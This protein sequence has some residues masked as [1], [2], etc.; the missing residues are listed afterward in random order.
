MTH[1]LK[2]MTTA[3]AA[4]A[5]FAIASSGPS[6]ALTAQECSAKYATAKTAGTLKGMKWNEFRKAECADA[7][8][9]APAAAADAK[10]AAKPATVAGAGVTVFPKA[11]DPQFAKETAGKARLHTCLAQYKANKATNANGGLKW[12]MK[13]GG[14]YSQ[15]NKGL[16]S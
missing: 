4:V 15:C 7:A 13:G 3:L 6:S 1:H 2:S 14:Y 10:P 8:A 9:P 5:A 12:I 11:V 16:K